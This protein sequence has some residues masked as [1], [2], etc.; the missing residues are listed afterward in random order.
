MPGDHKPS[1]DIALGQLSASRE[2]AD[3]TIVGGQPRV[4]RTHPVNIPV[5]VERVLYVAATDPEFR[6]ALLR[7][8]DRAAA[9]RGF[10]L[11][12]AEVAMLRVPTADQ[13]G[14]TIDRLDTSAPNVERRQFM[15][16]VAATAV[17]AAA[18]SALAACGDEEVTIDSQPPAADAGILVDAPPPGADAGVRDMPPPDKLQVDAPSALADAGISPGENVIKWDMPVGGFDSAGILPDGSK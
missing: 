14:A 15:R 11:R 2:A 12:P 4:K 9:E 7:D 6:A 16:A 3:T 5:G 17:A 8:R 18:G 10:D 1:R 13:L